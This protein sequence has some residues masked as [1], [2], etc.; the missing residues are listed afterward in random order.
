MSILNNIG[1]TTSDF[2]NKTVEKAQKLTEVNKLNGQISAEEK[3]MKSLVSEVGQLYI[4][5]HKEDYE[6]QFAAVMTKI[7]EAEDRIADMRQQ[8]D[9]L[10]GICHCPRCNAEVDLHA[11]FCSACGAAMPRKEEPIP[12]GCTR[13]TNCGNIIR[14]GMHFCTQCGAPVTAVPVVT[15]VSVEPVAEEAPAAP[16]EPVVEEAP[17]TPAEP[18]VEEAPA[19]PAEP[20]VEEAPA[21]PAEPVVEE[22]PAAPAEP[23][24][25]ETPAAPANKPAAGRICPSCGAAVADNML[26][27]IECGQRLTQDSPAE[28]PAPAVQPDEEAPEIVVPAGYVRCPSCGCFVPEGNRFCIECGQP[29]AAAPEKPEEPDIPKGMTRC[30]GCGS[31]V[32][33]GMKFCIECGRPMTAAPVVDTPEAEAPVT[34][35]SEEKSSH[36]TIR[37]IRCGSVIDAGVTFCTECGFPVPKD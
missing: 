6:P 36:K 17:A 26:F 37:C 24:V 1:R 2:T 32:P 11:A 10:R 23:V 29:L 14:A 31:I 16:T 15:E 19:A 28:D 35:E 34:A 5:V 33:A 18:V 9:T 25:E 3:A 13:C 21:A 22:A 27:C 7:R 4:S 8:I 30:E 12:D 20:V